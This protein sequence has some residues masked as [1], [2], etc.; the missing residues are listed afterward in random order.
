MKRVGFKPDRKFVPKRKQRGKAKDG[1]KQVR[2]AKMREQA[3]RKHIHN[4]KL[5]GKKKEAEKA[6]NAK[7]VLARFMKKDA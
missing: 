6:A 3:L 4:E 5:K 1:A 7:D 2:K